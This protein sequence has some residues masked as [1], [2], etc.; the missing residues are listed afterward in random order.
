MR[1][2]YN[3]TLYPA[4]YLLTVP[5]QDVGYLD[6]HY[7]DILGRWLDY[8]QTG[9]PDAVVQPVLTHCDRLITEAVRERTHEAFAFAAQKQVEWI[10]SG[11]ERHQ[12][13]ID[14]AHRTLRVQDTVMCVSSVPW[15]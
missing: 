4:L 9:A 1:P 8:L 5:A 15:W 7:S 6:E 10:N 3:R 13:A 11:I 2:A 12:S 14:D